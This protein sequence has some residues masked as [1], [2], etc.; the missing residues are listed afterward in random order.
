MSVK[1]TL[2][3]KDIVWLGS[4]REDVLAFPVDVRKEVGYQ[5]HSIQFGIE[6][7]D[8]KPFSEVGAGVNE[9]RVRDISGIYRVMY[10]AKFDEAIYVLHSFQKKTPQTSK[11]DKDIAKM[12]YNTL[13][14]QRR[15]KK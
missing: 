9:I 5:L 6:P 15:N 11:A 12:R 1:T 3:A 4:S 2:K 10:V 7:A 13:I 14:Q 8:W